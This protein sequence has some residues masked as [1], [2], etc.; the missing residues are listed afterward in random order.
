[1]VRG[2][3]NIPCADV[4]EACRH[5][6]ECRSDEPYEPLGTNPWYGDPEQYRNCPAPAPA[7]TSPSTRAG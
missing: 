1:M 4:P 5:P 3:R 6:K 7:A 2:A